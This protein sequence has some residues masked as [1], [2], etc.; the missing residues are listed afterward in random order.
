M[1]ADWWVYE[2]DAL[3]ISHPSEW[4]AVTQMRGCR[5]M[6]LTTGGSSDFRSSLTITEETAPDED[7]DR[8]LGGLIPTLDRYLTD[9][10]ANEVADAAISGREGKLVRGIYRQGRVVVALDQWMVPT[11]DRLFAISA[12]YDSEQAAGFFELACRA[13]ASLEFL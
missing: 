10:V 9:Y 3:R 12:S 1:D 11:D 8:L 13:V 6:F 4:R 2:D 7:L 5:V